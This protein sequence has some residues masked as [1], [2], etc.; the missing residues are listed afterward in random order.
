TSE[1]D[2]CCSTRHLTR[3]S[4]GTYVRKKN[5]RKLK[6]LRTMNC[7]DRY[8]V[9][10]DDERLFFSATFLCSVLPKSD[11][12]PFIAFGARPSGYFNP[13]DETAQRTQMKKRCFAT[14]LACVPALHFRF[15]K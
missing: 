12:L 15:L 4:P 2:L 7:T 1:W 11:K 3:K 5:G 9:R 8:C 10:L 14:S 13:C 6:P